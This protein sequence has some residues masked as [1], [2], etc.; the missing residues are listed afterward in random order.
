M[1]EADKSSTSSNNTRPTQHLYGTDTAIIRGLILP[2]KDPYC[3]ASFLIEIRLPSEYPFKMPE[4][5]I[6]DPIYHPNVKENGMHCCCWGLPGGDEWKPTTSLIE[7]IK[8]LIHTIDYIGSQH[9]TFNACGN[10][11]IINYQK[12]YE[13]ALEYTLKYGRP[14]C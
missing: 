6:L 11:Y 1:F 5:V 13:K 10:E 8:A 9:F 3:L 2:E 7:C 14:R 12:F 4:M